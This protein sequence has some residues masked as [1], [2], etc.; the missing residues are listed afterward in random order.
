MATI[1]D[2]R[3]AAAAMPASARAAAA[4]VNTAA[5][6]RTAEAMRSRLHSRTGN[7]ANAIR[8]RVDAAKLAIAVE[9]IPGRNT[10]AAVFS[11]EFGSVN[12]GARPFIR[13]AQEAARATI[14][15]EQE[16][17]VR[18]ALLELFA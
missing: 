2:L 8:I 15:R 7:L 17:A 5:A 6:A 1:D 3:R 14:A 12:M 18:T 10:R 11:L 13:P 16:Q 9:D 4:R